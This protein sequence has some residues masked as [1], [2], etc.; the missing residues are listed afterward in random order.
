MLRRYIDGEFPDGKCVSTMG[1]DRVRFSYR[2]LVSNRR[3]HTHT[4]PAVTDTSRRNI[5][6]KQANQC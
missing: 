3:T 1:I 5:V 6:G 2:S 4:Q